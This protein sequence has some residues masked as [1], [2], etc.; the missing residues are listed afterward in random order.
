MNETIFD[1][2]IW[3]FGSHRHLCIS[4]SKLKV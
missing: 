1:V 3:L 4:C 2:D